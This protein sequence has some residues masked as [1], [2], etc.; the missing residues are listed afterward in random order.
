MLASPSIHAQRAENQVKL[1]PNRVFHRLQAPRARHRKVAIV[2][3]PHPD[4]GNNL[5]GTVMLL[6]QVRAAPGRHRPLLLYFRAKINLTRLHRLVK[7]YRFLLKLLQGNKHRQI[8]P[9]GLFLAYEQLPVRSNAKSAPILPRG[10]RNRAN[11]LSVASFPSPSRWKRLLYSVVSV[12]L[13]ALIASF[14]SSLRQNPHLSLRAICLEAF[15]FS[16]FV[17][18]PCLPGWLLAL[19]FILSVTNLSKWRFLAFWALG[20]AIGPLVMLG[21]SLVFFLRA[22]PAATFF[23]PEAMAWF[24]TSVACLATLIYLL[25]VRYDQ[26]R[27]RL[28]AAI[29]NP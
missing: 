19:P 12:I 22:S 3:S 8:L 18:A 7:E 11:I 10:H 24:A 5:P 2:G 20:T 28:R 17:L 21:I 16:L 26:H 27:A 29:R 25:L 6:N 4:I 13:G 23:F 9:E 15:V 14:V 1:T